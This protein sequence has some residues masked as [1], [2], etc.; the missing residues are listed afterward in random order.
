M[1][2]L[3]V[4]DSVFGNTEKVAQAMGEALGEHAEV[5]TRRVGD[6]TFDIIRERVFLS[7]MSMPPPGHSRG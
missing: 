1:K 6:R 4:Y 2:A 5:A 7:T 3:V